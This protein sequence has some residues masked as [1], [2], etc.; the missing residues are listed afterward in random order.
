[1]FETQGT[2][3]GPTECPVWDTASCEKVEEGEEGELQIVSYWVSAVSEWVW[4]AV[5]HAEAGEAAGWSCQ[6]WV[7][8]HS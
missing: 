4:A 3:K 6:Q 1:M 7:A 2:A 5:R 8:P